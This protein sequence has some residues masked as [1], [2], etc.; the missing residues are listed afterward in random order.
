MTGAGG[1]TGRAARGTAFQRARAAAVGGAATILAHLPA[2]V[3]GGLCDAVGE[4]WYRVAPARAATARGNLAHV[5]AW[6]AAN[7]RGS[8]RARAAAADPGVLERLVRAAFRHGV[9]AYAETLRGTATFRDVLARLDVVTPEAVDAAFAVGAPAVFASMHFGSM[10]AVAAVLADR[11]DVPVTA[12]MET[13]DD[14]ELQRV[15]RRGRETGGARTVALADARRE[16]RAALARGEFVGLIADRDIRGGGIPV[17]LFGLP[18]PLPIGP[19]FLA[20]EAS[21]PLHVSAAI[22]TRGGGY[23]GWLETLPVPP[24]DLRRRARVEAL[25]A[26]QAAAFERLI[27]EAPE[28][29]STVFYP[30]WDEVGPR[31]R[32]AR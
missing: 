21:V 31:A 23:R 26:A 27:G 22:R 30:I 6:L 16:L 20:L 7:N 15:L 1:G 13:I 10:S 28:Q 32:G 24:P 5:V 2:G 8:R 9:R 11:S 18:A 17:M 19:A 3:V 25:M 12:P 14:P 4:L 29:W